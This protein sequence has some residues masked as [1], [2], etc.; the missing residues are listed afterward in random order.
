MHVLCG[1]ADLERGGVDEK[2]V[3]EVCLILVL[4]TKVSHRA[5]LPTTS[6]NAP[7]RT[8]EPVQSCDGRGP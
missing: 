6:L 1:D 3:G 2:L 4:R 7:Y 8:P 5:E